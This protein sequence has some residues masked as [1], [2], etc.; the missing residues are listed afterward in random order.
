MNVLMQTGMK[1][2][3]LELEINEYAIMENVVHAI[4]VMEMLTRVGVRFAID[5]FGKGFSCLAHLR[6]LPVAKLKIDR[7]FTRYVP[8]NVLDVKLVNAVV[9]LAR[10]L[11]VQTVAEGVEN[12]R[13]C[14]F[15][16]E[17][18]CDL[19][20]GY[21]F[22]PPRS[23]EEICVYFTGRGRTIPLPV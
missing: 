12:D 6:H 8:D 20:Q 13:Q 17:L 23:A 10:S 18:Q 16:R 4:E 22:G 5:D 19:A 7:A 15:F 21:L 3:W 9:A 14:E 2:C 11:G 1:P